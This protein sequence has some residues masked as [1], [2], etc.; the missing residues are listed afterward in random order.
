MTHKR[1][2]VRA[3]VLAG[4]VIVAASVAVAVWMHLTVRFGASPS[5]VGGRAR[6]SSG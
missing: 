3:E 2:M 4:L 6:T 5:A 1:L